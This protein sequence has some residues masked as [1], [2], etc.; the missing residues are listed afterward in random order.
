M[1]QYIKWDISSHKFL[2]GVGSGVIIL[3]LCALNLGI[4]SAQD[5]KEIIA[6]QF[7]HQQLILARQASQEIESSFDALIEELLILKNSQRE[8]SPDLLQMIFQRAHRLGARGLLVLN[9]D[10]KVI[11]KIGE[12][13]LTKLAPL[14]PNNLAVH[15]SKSW[16]YISEPLR[17]KI[18]VLFIDPYLLVQ[19]HVARIRSGKTGYAWVIDE[20]GYF[21]YHPIKSFIGQNAFKVRQ[22]KAPDFY[23]KKINKIQRQEMLQGKEGIGEY[24]SLWHRDVKGYVKK[25]VAYTPIHIPYTSHIWS[26]AVCVPEKEVNAVIHYLYLKQFFIQGSLILALIGLGIFALSLERGFRETLRQEV[27]RKTEVLKKSEE[28]YRLLIESADDLILTLD[29]FGNII[30]FNQATASFFK[31]KPALLHG[32]PF[33]VIMQWPPNTIIDCLNQLYTTKQSIV[34]EHIVKINGRPHWLNTKLMPLYLGEEIKEI[35]CI[36]RDIT[37]EKLVQEQLSNAEKMAS[38]GTLAAG[39]AHE[40]NN[41]LGIIIGFGELLLENT[42]RETQA[43]QDIKLILKHA[44]HCKSIV[45]NLLNFARP[46]E[47][48][49]KAIDINE[50]IKEV[51]NVVRHTL[52]INNIQMKIE[53]ASSLPLVQGDKKQLQQ[54]FL[55]LIINA[56]DAM[57]DGGELSITTRLDEQ[58]AIEV[59]FQD[60]G[61]GIKEEDLGKIFDPFFTTKP[62]GRGTG[63]GLSIS[64][65]IISKHNGRIRC[66]SEENKGATFIIDL[67]PIGGQYAR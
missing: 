23:F 59:L 49:S 31:K 63:L 29:M 60:T 57:P 44:L 5:L 22:E 33:N 34:K 65:S 61:C 30:S 17:K 64:Y 27:E 26:V 15:L 2:L 10:K 1:K 3:L 8:P 54:V 46:T 7:N 32:Q 37:K 45:Q 41:P 67:P 24:I 38:L 62:E 55:N 66:E 48:L 58:Q 18:I 4:H 16:V 9:Q 11:Y 39:V 56:M 13:T 51:I 43:Y 50:A 14:D 20:N 53:F 6:Q 35:L 42:P 12:P 52:E 19:R 47:D 28:K 21:I 25:F 36:A 40:I